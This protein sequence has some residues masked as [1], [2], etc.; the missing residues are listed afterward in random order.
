MSVVNDQRL[1]LSSLEPRRT[2][3]GGEQFKFEPRLAKLQALDDFWPDRWRTKID[4]SSK[5]IELAQNQAGVVDWVGSADSN[6]EQKV[7]D[8]LVRL[9]VSVS[10][11]AMHLGREVR[12]KIF[13]DLDAIINVNDWYP[14]DEFPGSNSFRDFLKW[15]VYTRRFDWSSLG[16]ADNGDLLI[17]WVKGDSLLTGHFDGKGRIWW[18]Y[19]K[20]TA[21]G[22]EHASGDC[23]L[24]RF[25]RQYD[26]YLG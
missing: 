23:T 1:L 14:E 21:D 2:E 5:G 8:A 3:F 22:A 7:F 9:K 19:K 24:Q 11:Y 16:V 4:R 6:F 26:F 25:S 15:T 17:A 18:A 20:E 10:Q 13:A 12:N